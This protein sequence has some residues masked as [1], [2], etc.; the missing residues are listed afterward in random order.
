MFPLFLVSQAY[1]P[2]D[3]TPVGQG[4]WRLAMVDL[5]ANTFEFS[6]VLKDRVPRDPSGRAVITRAYVEAHA[7]E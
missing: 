4:R 2:V 1:Q 5:R 7:A 6:E 3:P